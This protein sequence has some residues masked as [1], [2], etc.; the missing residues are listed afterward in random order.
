M[1]LFRCYVVR[2]IP[3]SL[4][5]SGPVGLF[6]LPWWPEVTILPESFLVNWF[7]VVVAELPWDRPD[8]QC[9]EFS[10]YCTRKSLNVSPWNKIPNWPLCEVYSG[11]FVPPPLTNSLVKAN[12]KELTSRNSFYL[13]ADLFLPRGHAWL[14]VVDCTCLQWRASL[15]T[16]G[17]TK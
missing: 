12:W 17:R 6:L 7:T 10:D 15:V 1:F 14:Q 8:G 9:K 4:Q 11:L 2:S 13:V 3:L 5:I 16:L